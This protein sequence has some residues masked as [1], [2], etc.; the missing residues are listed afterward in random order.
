M[1]IDAHDPL[2]LSEG[3]CHQLD[4]ISYHPSVDSHDPLPPVPPQAPVL[5]DVPPEVV[6]PV[7][8]VKLIQTS[9]TTPHEENRSSGSDRWRER[10]EDLCC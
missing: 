7:V 10:F 9:T 5:Q 6:V 2:L 1:K 4:I 3:V 8:R